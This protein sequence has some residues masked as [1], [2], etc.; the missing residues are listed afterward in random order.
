MTTKEEECRENN[1]VY[2]AQNWDFYLTIN[3]MYGGQ[4]R[5]GSHKILK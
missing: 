4:E 1:S 2:H 3:E 5:Q